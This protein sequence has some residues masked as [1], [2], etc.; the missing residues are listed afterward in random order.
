MPDSKYLQVTPQYEATTFE[1]RVKPL[2]LYKQE[3]DKQQ[4]VYDKLLEDTLMLENLKGSDVDAD[5]YRQYSQWRGELNSAADTLSNTGI[6]D[7]QSIRDLRRQYLNEFKPMEDRYKHRNDLILRQA[8]EYSPYTLFDKDFSKISVAD[9]SLDDSYRT[10]KLD[11]IEK[12]AFATLSERYI[13]TG[14]PSDPQSDVDELLGEIDTTG[15]SPDQV[16]TIRDSILSGYTRAQRTVDEYNL[17][18]ERAR[19]QDEYQQLQMDRLRRTSSG[20]GNDS[21]NPFSPSKRNPTA[22]RDPIKTIDGNAGDKIPVYKLTD[23]G[24]DY[25]F[26]MRGSTPIQIG[27][28]IIKEDGSVTYS[29]FYNAVYG[30]SPAKYYDGQEYVVSNDGKVVSG[31]NSMYNDTPSQSYLLSTVDEVEKFLKDHSLWAGQLIQIAKDKYGVSDI[32]N[33]D[34]INFKDIYINI[35][36]PVENAGSFWQ[37]RAAVS[38]EDKSGRDDSFILIDGL[39]PSGETGGSGE[40]HPTDSTL[41]RRVTPSGGVGST[42]IR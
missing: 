11:D 3:Y 18:Q 31:L 1:E 41:T 42:V 14:V 13:Q 34:L 17:Q 6:L 40:T 2:V 30:R 38:L 7:M 36:D 22:G 16:D 20:D 15:L 35:Y 10:Y 27:S 26:V 24:K 8:A 37:P 21:S 19:R 9:I 39:A 23:D 33:S 25:Y 32:L 5:L 4:E 29:S 12:N 28:D